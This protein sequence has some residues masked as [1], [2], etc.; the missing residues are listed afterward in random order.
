MFA[1][2]GKYI[3]Y[4]CKQCKS[5]W[6]KSYYRN[7]KRKHDIAKS[8]YETSH[9]EKMNSIRRRRRVKLT[10]EQYEDILYL[11][12][13]KCIYCGAKWEEIDHYIPLSR[14]GDN[15]ITNLVPACYNCNRSK[16]RK[17]VSEWKNYSESEVS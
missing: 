10:T 9:R 8:K 17:L 4:T 6:F 11:F 16:G 3:L 5:E 14:G 15:E 12:N 2:N 13:E 1:S 7:N